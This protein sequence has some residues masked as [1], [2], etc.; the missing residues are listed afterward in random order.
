MTVP[1]HSPAAPRQQAKRAATIHAA[2]QAV[3]KA[4]CRAVRRG[5]GGQVQGESR[6]LRNG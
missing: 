4:L 2:A 5:E 1:P 3:P 6:V